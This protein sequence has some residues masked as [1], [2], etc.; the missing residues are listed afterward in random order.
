MFANLPTNAIQD[1]DLT[2][3]DV[4]DQVQ[5]LMGVP[6]FD[7]DEGLLYIVDCCGDEVQGPDNDLADDLWEALCDAGEGVSEWDVAEKEGVHYIPEILRRFTTEDGF[8]HA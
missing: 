5:E 3:N 1:G 6:W 4:S 2:W 7:D 8:H